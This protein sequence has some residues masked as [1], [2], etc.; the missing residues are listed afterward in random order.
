[1]NSGST[2]SG[3]GWRT[4]ADSESPKAGHIDEKC[5]E[6]EINVVSPGRTRLISEEVFS[7]KNPFNRLFG[8]LAQRAIR[9]A[10]RRHIEAFKRF[11]EEQA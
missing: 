4:R 2:R 10:H 8:F 3:T 5:C 11:A 1:V 9:N 6:L 7:F